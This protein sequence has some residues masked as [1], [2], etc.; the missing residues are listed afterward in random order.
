MKRTQLDRHT[1]PRRSQKSPHH[2]T[3]RAGAL[4]AGVLAAMFAVAACGTDVPSGPMD[5]TEL[6]TVAMTGRDVPEGWDLAE[7]PTSSDRYGDEIDEIAPGQAGSTEVSDCVQAQESANEATQDLAYVAESEAGYTR[8]DSAY[9]A[10]YMFSTD[11]E[12][13]LM[14]SIVYFMESC[15]DLALEGMGL[16]WDQTTTEIDSPEVDMIGVKMINDSA[17]DGG[18]VVLAGQ[19]YGQNHLMVM[20][21]SQDA[22]DEENLE[23][24]VDAAQ[25]RFEQGPETTGG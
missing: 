10:M 17:G 22:R 8:G 5:E 23:E 21:I 15:T 13:D 16:G 14:D 18:A 2:R 9:A 19:S 6:E 20:G 4:T 24:F 3:G 12:R 7:G 11:D 25:E 1:A